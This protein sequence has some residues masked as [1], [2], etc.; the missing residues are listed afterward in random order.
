ME[1][2]TINMQF[3]YKQKISSTDSAWRGKKCSTGTMIYDV[4]ELKSSSWIVSHCFKMSEKIILL[5]YINKDWARKYEAALC[6]NVWW[7][8]KL[9]NT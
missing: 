7:F 5:T 4:L 3:I 2:V 9:N 6:V 8:T 1:L